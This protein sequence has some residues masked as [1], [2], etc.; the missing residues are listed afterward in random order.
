MP[1]RLL[2]FMKFELKLSDLKMKIK[3]SVLVGHLFF[4]S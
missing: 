1:V 2:L 3:L 4:A